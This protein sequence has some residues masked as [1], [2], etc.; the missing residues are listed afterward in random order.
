MD[1]DE[2]TTI[3]MEDRLAA[4]KAELSDIKALKAERDE[5]IECINKIIT[6]WEAFGETSRFYAFIEDARA[7][8]SR[9][10]VKP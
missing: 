10:E 5:A 9:M 4:A 3:T 6:E 1:E 2:Y 7:F 8:L